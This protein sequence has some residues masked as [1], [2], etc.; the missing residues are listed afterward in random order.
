M[1]RYRDIKPFVRDAC[2]HVTVGWNYLERW[3][4]GL[5]ERIETDGKTIAYDGLVLCPDFQRG[6]V[7]TPAQQTAYV[8]YIL[9]AGAS[10][11]NIYLNNPTW[12]HGYSEPTVVVDGLQRITAVQQFIAGNVPA[13]GL[14]SNDW[15]GRIPDHCHFDAYVHNLATRAEVLEWYIGI[16]AGGTPHAPT[17]IERVRTLLKAEAPSA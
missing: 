5:K 1:P 8:E 17:E 7:W 14:R 13:F 11:K 15:E 4:E 12:G 10:G 9:R 6:H 16:N 3:L 2:Y